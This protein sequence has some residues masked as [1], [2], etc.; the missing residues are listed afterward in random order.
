MP[1]VFMSCVLFTYAPSVAALFHD[2]AFLRADGAMSH[3]CVSVVL[4]MLLLSFLVSNVADWLPTVIEY[5]VTQAIHTY[6]CV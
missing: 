2:S 5:V 3:A 1:N 4:F 6:T